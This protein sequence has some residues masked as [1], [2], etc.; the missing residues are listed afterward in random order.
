MT[1][2]LKY[3]SLYFGPL[4]ALTVGVILHQG[5]W[6]LQACF[7]AG[8]T[9]LCALWWVFEPI[10][11][12]ATSL[13]P[14]GGF[15]LLGVLDGQQ[16]AS[17]YGSPIILLLVGGAMMSKS[18]EKTGTHKR[19]AL[20][21]IHAIGTGSLRRLVWGF[22]AASAFLSMWISNTATTLMLVP[23]AMAV[24]DSTRDRRFTVAL[25]L[26]IAYAASIGGLATPIGTPPNL[27]FIS[28]YKEF[29][30]IDISFIGWMAIGL[31]VTLVLLPVAAIWLTRRL[32]YS[33]EVE[34][35][36]LGRITSGE[37]RVLAVFMV[38][39]I[40]WMTL[41]NPAGGWSGWLSL[42][43]ANYAS[44]AFIAVVVMFLCPD[45]EGG[46][47]LDWPA[48]SSIHWG[49]MILFAGG[50]AIAKAF[51]VT[52]LS[53]ALGQQLS[54]IAGWPLYAVIFSICLG[55]TFLTEVTSNTATTTLLMPILAA[56]GATTEWDPALLMI[57][58]ALSA[59]CAFMLP[60]ATA[61]NAIV[62][63]SGKIKVAEMMHEGLVLNVLGALL[64]S[65][66]IYLLLG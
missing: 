10:P 5:G 62:I 64:I 14:L 22:M 20:W 38:V 65:T 46:R 49:V 31:P 54:S 50:I 44:V 60:V 63:A 29:T 59:S 33:A 19:I 17:A 61:P 16:I 58:A 1:E 48:A 42:P 30:G 21:M 41:K 56:A 47:L 23:V 57:P 32:G 53:E 12:A 40:A 55:V 25:L 39:I 36:G 51:M 4:V 26:G 28:V 7:A 18:M 6:N 9:T 3:L 52:G 15:P 13:L 24:I 43:Y 2:R 45:G 66:L 34:I 27:I 37:R 11:I 35:S 8:I